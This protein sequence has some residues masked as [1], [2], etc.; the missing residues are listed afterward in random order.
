MPY[1][2]RDLQPQ[3]IGEPSPRAIVIYGARQIG[4]TTL[5]DQLA[6]TAKSVRRF[7][8]DSYGDRRQLNFQSAVDVELTLRQADT[9]IIDEAQT[10]PDAGLILKELLNNN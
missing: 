6:R 7:D 10:L 8:G 5:V 2:A 4:K 1:I 3:I 9:I